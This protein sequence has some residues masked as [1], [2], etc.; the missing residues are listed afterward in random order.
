MLPGT[1]APCS[2]GMHLIDMSGDVRM[3]ALH[4]MIEGRPLLGA[5]V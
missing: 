4:L 1:L 5:M 2:L 3:K